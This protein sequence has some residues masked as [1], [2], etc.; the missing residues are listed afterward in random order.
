MICVPLVGSHLEDLPL[1]ELSAAD[2]D[3]IV[4]L[5]VSVGPLG[6]HP[7]LDDAGVAAVQGV[8]TQVAAGKWLALL[9]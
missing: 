5:S 2:D 3:G 8:E 9:V 4:E 1:M 6:S 7:G